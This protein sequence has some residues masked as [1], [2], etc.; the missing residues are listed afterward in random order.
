M[1]THTCTCMRTG[2]STCTEWVLPIYIILY[3]TASNFY[4]HRA[5]PQTSWSGPLIWFAKDGFTLNQQAIPNQR[6]MPTTMVSHQTTEKMLKSRCRGGR[7]GGREGEREREREERPFLLIFTLVPVFSDSC[8]FPQTL[9][10]AVAHCAGAPG[11][12]A[13][14]SGQSLYTRL[15]VVLLSQY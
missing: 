4:R 12:L 3:T 15:K 10:V 5:G 2:K 7:E 13:E 11:T 9:A 8:S 1:Q 14:Y 6:L